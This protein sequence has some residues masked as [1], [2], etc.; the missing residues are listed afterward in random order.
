M[1]HTPTN[2]HDPKVDTDSRAPAAIAKSST[3]HGKTAG[4]LYRRFSS[5]KFSSRYIFVAE[6][7]DEN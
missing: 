5:F 1:N 7:T 3:A 6:H 2:F 4:L